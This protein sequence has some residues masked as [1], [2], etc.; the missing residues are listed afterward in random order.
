MKLEK[1]IL[2]LNEE[3][4]NLRSMDQSNLKKHVFPEIFFTKTK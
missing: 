2:S 3:V 4:D 1:E